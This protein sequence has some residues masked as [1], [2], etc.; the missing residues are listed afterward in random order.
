MTLAF[1]ATYVACTDALGGDILQVSFDTVLDD[2][3]NPRCS[4]YVLISRN[5]EF[6][7]SAAIEWHNGQ[8]YD[9]GAE[10]RSITLTRTHIT[11]RL[12]RELTI[13]VS[14]K[15]TEAAYTRLTVFLQRIMDDRIVFTE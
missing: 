3:E 8:D 9:G 11:L 12:N 4:P 15:L 1:K 7:E 5:F 6:P 2:D 13:A 10:I 14:F